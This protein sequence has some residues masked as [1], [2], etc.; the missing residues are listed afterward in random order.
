MNTFSSGRLEESEKYA[1]KALNINANFFDSWFFL[2]MIYL[3]TGQREKEIVAL[4]EE[5]QEISN[6]NSPIY[7][8]LI[9]HY[10]EIDPKK[11]DEY[12]DLAD[13][14]DE[15]VSNTALDARLITKVGFNEF[16][17]L[18]EEAYENNTLPFNFELNLFVMDYKDNPKYKAFVEKIRKGK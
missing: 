5:I 1:K 6:K 12:Y 14:Y 15:S 8:V 9:H 17:K 3:Q 4:I 2:Y 13:K 11:S 7:S 16:L 10:Q 18:A